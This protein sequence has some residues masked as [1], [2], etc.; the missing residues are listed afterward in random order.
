MN[1]PDNWK[2][3]TGT[4]CNIILNCIIVV[5][6][7]VILGVTINLYNNYNK[8][9]EENDILYEFIENFDKYEDPLEMRDQ[10]FDEIQFLYE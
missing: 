7:M 6:A 4:F 1:E 8:V 2:I 5:I 3:W 10:V 9:R